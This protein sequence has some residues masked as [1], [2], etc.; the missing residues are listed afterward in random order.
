MEELVTK[1]I[2]T[3]EEF[4]QKK[5]K[6][7]ELY[8]PYVKNAE[9]PNLETYPKYK[10]INVTMEK[11]NKKVNEEKIDNNVKRDEQYHK[12]KEQEEKALK[13]KMEREK[14]EKEKQHHLEQERLE[15]ERVE[16]ERLEKARI[17]KERQEQLEMVKRLQEE[18]AKD[19]ERKEREK[20][21]QEK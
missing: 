17:E 20:Q 19:R 6:L 18:R 21:E 16:K 9:K 15:K 1:G 10:K 2:L 4:S 7:E 5:R 12:T 11:S 3:H 8:G 13:E 14:I